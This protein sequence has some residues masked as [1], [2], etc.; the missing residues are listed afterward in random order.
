MNYSKYDKVLLVNNIY[1]NENKVWTK[2]EYMPLED[3][4]Y[5]FLFHN[6]WE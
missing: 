1:I 2:Y 3:I 4:G 5:S 6:N